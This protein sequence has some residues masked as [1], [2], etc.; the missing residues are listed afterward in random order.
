MRQLIFCALTSFLFILSSCQ[1]EE[2]QPT[3]S[4]E[5]DDL[6]E[7][8]IPNAPNSTL[9]V[10]N[11]NTSNTTNTSNTSNTSNTNNILT[12]V[13]YLENHDKFS[14]FY[15]ALVKTEMADQVDTNGHFT[16]FVPDNQ[17]FQTFFTNN[18]WT[19][20]DDV[21]TNI[22]TLIVKFHISET[23]V[24]IEDLTN[25]V[26]VPIMFNDKNVYINIDDPNNPFVVLGL[27]SADVIESD[28][29]QSNGVIHHINGVLS[30]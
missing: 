11:G 7:V 22:L 17:A 8:T 20:L 29:M 25:G 4:S 21:P 24:T 1:K 15:E 27:T 19:T 2:I 18:N 10:N 9:S 3:D 30:L 16:F 5:N 14:I 23:Q 12:L 26:N 28:M 13:Q 6:I